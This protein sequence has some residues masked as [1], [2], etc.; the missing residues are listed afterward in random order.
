L[1]ALFARIQE[2]PASVQAALLREL[3]LSDTRHTPA[4]AVLV[5][6]RLLSTLGGFP[7]GKLFIV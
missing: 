3:K 5:A 2:L 1:G 6:M 4:G 7:P